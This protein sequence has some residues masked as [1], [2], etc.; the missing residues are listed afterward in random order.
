MMSG[1]A[2]ARQN[3]IFVLSLVSSKSNTD[4]LAIIPA[5]LLPVWVSALSG[6]QTAADELRHL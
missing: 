3:C 1:I 5:V 4:V 6:S 2:K